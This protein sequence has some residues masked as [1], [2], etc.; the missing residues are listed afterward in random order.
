MSSSFLN[1]SA[2]FH[3]YSEM[4][5]NFN[6][7]SQGTPYNVISE[8]QILSVSSTAYKVN[9]TETAFGT[10]ASYM[11][12]V[13]KNGTLVSVLYQGQN[14][15][16]FYAYNFYLG[17]MAAFI[18]ESTFTS[19][20]I[21]ASITSPL[22]VHETSH[23]T[24]MIGPTSVLAT[25]YVANTLPLVI[26]ECGFSANFSMFSIQTGSVTGVSVPLITAMSISGT[27]TSGGSSQSVDFGFQITS[28]TKAA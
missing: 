27:M 16:G 10:T 12:Y 5:V 14:Y 15:T 6:E 25:T 24:I 4:K 21:F 3:A 7:T 1:F 11:A 13:L 26:N 20:E 8:Y 28:I 22:F 9:I 23:A 2:T 18:F 19:P 17:A